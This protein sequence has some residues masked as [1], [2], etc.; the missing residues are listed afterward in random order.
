MFCGWKQ[1]QFNA[2]STNPRSVFKNID[3]GFKATLG[4]YERY[5]TTIRCI[6]FC[7]NNVITFLR[8]YNVQFGQSFPQLHQKK[9]NIP[10]ETKFHFGFFMLHFR[11]Y[12]IRYTKHEPNFVKTNLYHRNPHIRRNYHEQP[13]IRSGT[14]ISF[15]FKD[16][17]QR[18]TKSFHCLHMS[19][20]TGTKLHH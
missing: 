9:K 20:F 13:N 5:D 16:R 15:G 17:L 18:V 12:K 4:S 6:I 10:C 11:G 2:L 8:S 1:E 7:E 19:V 3:V 14:K